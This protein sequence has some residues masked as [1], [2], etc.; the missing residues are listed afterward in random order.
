[1][2][3]KIVILLAIVGLFILGGCTHETQN[4]IGCSI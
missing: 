1:M 3:N 2:K 4:K